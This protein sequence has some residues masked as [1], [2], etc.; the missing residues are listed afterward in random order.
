MNQGMSELVQYGCFN[1]KR[2][3]LLYVT[4]LVLIG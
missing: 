1:T 3:T 2:V 4:V